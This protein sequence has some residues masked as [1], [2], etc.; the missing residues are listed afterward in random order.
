MV[1][2]SSWQPIN[3]GTVN[4]GADTNGRWFT[5]QVSSLELEGANGDA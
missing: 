1:A 4:L 3:Y 2:A 5:A